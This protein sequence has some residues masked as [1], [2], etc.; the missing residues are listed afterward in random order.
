MKKKIFLAL[1][2][3][4]LSSLFVFGQDYIIKDIKAA[5]SEYVRFFSNIGFFAGKV[6]IHNGFLPLLD[7]LHDTDL[8]ALTKEEL[9]I[10]RNVIYAKHG[11]IFQ[12]DDLKRHFSKF[13]WYKPQ[14]RDVE[15]N[16]TAYEKSTIRRILAFEEGQPNK[17]LTK[18]DLVGLWSELGVGSGECDNISFGKKNTVEF[19]Y[20]TMY[21]KAAFVCRGTYAVENG[22]LV[23]LITEQSLRI[24]DYFH[25]P[26]ASVAGGMEGNYD[27]TGTLKFDK[28]IKMIF[29]VSDFKS[30]YNGS[31]ISDMQIRARQIGSLD[32]VGPNKSGP[33]YK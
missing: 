26:V 3:L 6:I 23:V 25:G 4:N 11:Y 33:D 16:L 19:G 12:S 20:N 28:P 14:H 27:K 31:D 10:L 1:L 21:P 13:S 29:P 5:D 24:G 7:D 15:K 2:L 17:K 9:R 8:A 30:S 18:E 32:R 22:Y